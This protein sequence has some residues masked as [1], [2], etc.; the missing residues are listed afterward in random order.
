MRSLEGLGQHFALCEI[1]IYLPSFYCRVVH[2]YISE[3][4]TETEDVE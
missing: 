1:G 3:M 2:A 4:Q